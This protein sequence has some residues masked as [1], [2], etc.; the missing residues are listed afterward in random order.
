ME[1]SEL[2]ARLREI[3]TRYR[4]SKHYVASSEGGFSRYA[5]WA[6]APRHPNTPGAK[7]EQVTEPS[8]HREAQDM[9]VSLTVS[10]IADLLETAEQ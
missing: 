10:D 5:V 9:R 4:V 3:L 1:R 2:E 8:N 6:G 7:P